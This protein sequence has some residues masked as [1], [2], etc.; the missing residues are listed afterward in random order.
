VED[1][2]LVRAMIDRDNRAWTLFIRRFESVIR[3]RI[4][5]VF[6]RY[7]YRASSA[8]YQEAFDF[9]LDHFMFKKTLASFK[10]SQ[11]LPGFVTCV[12]TNAVID[13]YRKRSAARNLYGLQSADVVE[14]VQAECPVDAGGGDDQNQRPTA[15]SQL[16]DDV[17]WAPE[18]LAVLQVMS[19]RTIDLSDLDIEGIAAMAREDIAVTEPKLEALRISLHERWASN[20]ELYDEIGLLWLKS[21]ILE[22]R[23][24]SERSE[25]RK[26]L[27]DKRLADYRAKGIEPYPTRREIAE[28][29]NWDINKVDRIKRKIE[30]K[31]R[32]HQEQGGTVKTKLTR[33]A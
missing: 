28:V 25:K 27:L 26:S 16:F 1:A 8:D 13:W 22:R 32:N 11:S 10:R 23:E 21:I 5:Q 31:L 29:F 15:Q 12:T 2:K 18:E 14:L 17:S 33:T 4:S 7:S 9:V 24:D 19:V 6:Y 20:R 3:R 30:E